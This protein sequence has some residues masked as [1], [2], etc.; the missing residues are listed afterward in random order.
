MASKLKQ[1]PSKKMLY[2]PQAVPDSLSSPATSGA[3]NP[4]VSVKRTLR[5]KKRKPQGAKAGALS[6]NIS[7]MFK[8]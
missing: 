4:D 2:P 6:T 3:A 1:R 7:G 8:S 5:A